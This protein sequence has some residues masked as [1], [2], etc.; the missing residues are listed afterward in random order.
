MKKIAPTVN[1]KR[2]S[3]DMLKFAFHLMVC[4]ERRHLFSKTIAGPPIAG[5]MN[6]RI[7]T[8]HLKPNCGSSFLNMMKKNDPAESA[9]RSHYIGSNPT[10]TEEPVA[11]R[12]DASCPDSGAG[13]TAENA[14]IKEELVV[15]CAGLISVQLVLIVPRQSIRQYRQ[16][17]PS[18]KHT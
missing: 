16:R 9:G 12:G 7:R 1:T 2:S 4:D 17:V 5:L 6:P 14:K 15:F 13:E 11:C 10:T 3:V 8:V 18:K